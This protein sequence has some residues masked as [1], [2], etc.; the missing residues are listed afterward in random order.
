[1][2]IGDRELC[3]GCVANL[4]PVKSHMTLLEALTRVSDQDQSW[5]LL[6][7]GE[8]TERA[9]LAA[10]IEARPALKKRVSLLGSSHR[11]PELLQAM[12]VFVLPSVAEGI[13]NSLL[14]AMA[15]G[16]AVITTAVGGNPEVVIHGES[17][18]LFSPG[19]AD[20]LATHLAR[21]KAQPALRQQLGRGAR[22]RVRD[23]FSIA[24]MVQGYEQLY[25]T[26]RP[27]GIP[28]LSAG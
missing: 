19:D 28:V 1:L 22:Q 17:G 4:L 25:T 27:A 14:E 5:R 18:V 12:D 9:R 8:G 26:L 23:D 7:V 10:F 20:A 3:I 16:L 24:S 6:L 11:V 13:C 15:T 21:L 2:E